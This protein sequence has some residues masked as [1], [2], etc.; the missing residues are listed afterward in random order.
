M[1]VGINSSN[2]FSIRMLP[3]TLKPNS[4]NCLLFY[5]LQDLFSFLAALCTFGQILDVH[6]FVLFPPEKMRL[7]RHWITL[8]CTCILFCTISVRGD[9]RNVHWSQ[10]FCKV[11]YSRFSGSF[12]LMTW[13]DSI[14]RIAKIDLISM[15]RSC[16]NLTI[17]TSLDKPSFL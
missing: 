10:G 17:D 15:Q 7:E 9:L 13:C 6:N 16:N 1:K 2:S 3:I 5:Y 14:F 12:L 4:L 11:M 8:K